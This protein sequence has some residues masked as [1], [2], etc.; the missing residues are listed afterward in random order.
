MSYDLWFRTRDGSR[1]DPQALTDYFQQRPNY[2]LSEQQAVYES[3]ATGVYF[4]F[5]IGDPEVEDQ[6]GLAPLAFNLNYMRPHIFGLE[7]EPELRALC[8]QFGLLVSDPQIDG[9]GEGE[10]SAEKF[11]S[12]WNAGNEMG[13]R[14][15]LKEQLA[16]EVFSLPTAQIEACWRW[17]MAKDALQ[18]AFGE[19]LFVPKLFFFRHGNGVKSAVVWPDGIPIA[20]P[21]SDLVA[22]QRK[23][24]LPKRFFMSREDFVIAER[25]EL[26]AVLQEFPLE[27]GAQPY[28]LLNYEA[29]PE[30]VLAC[31][32][33]LTATKEKP[34]AVST[35]RVLTA[36]LVAK[37]RSR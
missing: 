12:G 26:E 2:Q 27:Q 31:L 20:M 22:I 30:T 8:E 21:D 28:R 34:E 33:S 16:E 1:L 32:R 19:S 10:F 24:I 36:E 6:P 18:E 11:L 13:Y 5:D 9:M 25:A 14:A 7:A 17:N 4:I 35:D 15:Y 37:V 23:D 29:V 3:D